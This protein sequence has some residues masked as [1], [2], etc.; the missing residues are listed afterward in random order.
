[1]RKLIFLGAP[2]PPTAGG[3]PRPRGGG[4]GGGV[5]S[6][7]RSPAVPPVAFVADDWKAGLVLACHLHARGWRLLGGDY[8]L[9]ERDTLTVRP[10][11]KQLY[12]TLSVMDGLPN[13]YRRGRRGGPREPAPPR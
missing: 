4:G 1:M 9:I 11:K 6:A 8:A 5:G 10:T 3:G 2:P 13:A 12:P 7:P